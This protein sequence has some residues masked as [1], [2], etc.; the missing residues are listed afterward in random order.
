MKHLTLCVLFFLACSDTQSEHHADI[1]AIIADRCSSCHGEGKIE[2][3]LFAQQGP[4]MLSRVLDK[5]M[6]PGQPSSLTPPLQHDPRLSA[7]EIQIFRDWAA[8]G[9]PE[10][11]PAKNNP[12]GAACD[13]SVVMANPYTPPPPLPGGSMDEYRCFLLPNAAVQGRTISSF[14]WVVGQPKEMH[15]IVAVVVDAAGVA[16]YQGKPQGWACAQ[17]LDVAFVASLGSGGMF[18]TSLNDYGA[19]AGLVIPPGGGLVIQM[20]YLRGLGLPDQSGVC[21]NFASAPTPRFMQD[22]I[23]TAP[24]ELPCPS[25]VSSDPMSGCNRDNAIDKTPDSWTPEQVRQTNDMQLKNCGYTLQSYYD[26]QDFGA[27]P[28]LV[29]ST[30]SVPIGGNGNIR[31]VHLHMHTY[32]KNGQLRLLHKD[33]TSTLLL[34]FSDPGYLWSWE[35]IFSL[36]SPIAVT[37]D[38]RL[39]VTCIWDNSPENQ[40]SATYGPSLTDKKAVDPIRPAYVPGISARFAEMCDGTIGVAILR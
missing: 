25:G 5:S 2:H 33:H 34:D 38:D 24:A 28:F 9:F 4:L 19:D 30:C 7:E 36:A 1:S 29:K 3:T 11:E 35:S 16:K 21:L 39:E 13:T 22:I 15:H 17:G 12:P 23:A 18:D 27:S 26:S 40:W 8:S 14:R 20:H 10:F 6:P 37:T 31:T 32:G